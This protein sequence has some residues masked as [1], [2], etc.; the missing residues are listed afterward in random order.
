MTLT[1]LACTRLSCAKSEITH[2]HQ[3]KKHHRSL[4]EA[5]LQ[6]LKILR[7]RSRQSEFQMQLF[8][9]LNSLRK[10]KR[11]FFDLDCCRSLYARW[12][13]SDAITVCWRS[14]TLLM[15]GPTGAQTPAIDSGQLQ[16]PRSATAAVQ[17]P[18]IS[19]RLKVSSYL[20]AFLSEAVRSEGRDT[21][22]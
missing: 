8:L 17:S 12:S 10:K 14:D 18:R 13:R 20:R 21:R 2:P 5:H 22:S 6:S 19:P 16:H 15:R 4:L 11:R 9:I 3:C 1:W 7:S